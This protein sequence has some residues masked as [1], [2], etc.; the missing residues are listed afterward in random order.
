MLPG[1]NDVVIGLETRLIEAIQTHLI[2]FKRL[3]IRLLALA[4]VTDGIGHMSHRQLACTRHFEDCSSATCYGPSRFEDINVRGVDAYLIRRGL[5]YLDLR[6]VQ[7]MSVRSEK[8]P[9]SRKT[10]TTKWRPP[11]GTCSSQW[12]K[13]SIMQHLG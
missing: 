12:R 1:L 13:R 10:Q 3:R 2:S 6:P 7:K 9:M 11:Q 5:Y 4:L 8:N